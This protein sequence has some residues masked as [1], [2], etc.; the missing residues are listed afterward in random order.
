MFTALDFLAV[1]LASGAIIEVWHK[2]SILDNWRAWAQTAQDIAPVES[3]RGRGLELLNC[4]F[5][6]SYH[7]PV[8]LFLLLALA[9]L[10][11]G[12]TMSLLTRVVVYGLGATRAG[13]ILDGLLPARM[14]YIPEDGD[15]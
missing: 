13:N 5:C 12:A 8:Y 14:R 10:F 9:D 11:G 3:W 1:L 6:K 7:V 4:P 2:G 15:S